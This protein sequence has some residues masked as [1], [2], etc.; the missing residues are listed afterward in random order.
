MQKK[1][2]RAA[3]SSVLRNG[4]PLYGTIF[5]RILCRNVRLQVLNDSYGRDFRYLFPLFLGATFLSLAEAICAPPGA[6]LAQ[7]PPPQGAA[8]ALA[9]PPVEA[10]CAAFKLLLA[11]LCHRV[12]L[13]DEVASAAR[14][15]CACVCAV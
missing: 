15:V 7:K 12:F 11:L 1:E 6:I 14:D 5:L 3:P 8:L 13:L 10:I 2:L 4:F 9:K